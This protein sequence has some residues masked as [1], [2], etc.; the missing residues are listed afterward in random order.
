MAI[1][2][3][4]LGTE[5]LVAEALFSVLLLFS[6]GSLFGPLNIINL[7]AAGAILF[8][9]WQ[10][11][12]ARPRIANG[13]ETPSTTTPGDLH[14]AYAGALA[15]GRVTDNQLEA[16]VLEMV[17]RKVIE[18]EPDQNDREKVQIRILQ[19]SE[20]RNPVETELISLLKSRATSGVIDYRTLSRVRNQWGSVRNTLQKDLAYK[21]WLN[22]SVL[23]TRMPFILPGTLGVLLAFAMIP[24]AFIVGSGWPLLG[25]VIVGIVGCIVLIIGNIIP[26]TTAEGEKEALPWRGYRTGLARARDESSNA[27]D[28]DEAFPYIVAM[29]MAPAF[30]RY[31]RRAS[32]SG[33]I[34]IWIGPRPRVQEWPEGW[35][36]YWI[37]VHTALAPTD[38]ANTRAPSGSAWRRS[39]TG[40]R[41]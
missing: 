6:A 18:L 37:A 1:A 15:T 40:G 17:R 8:I 11:W 29:G 2:S 32:Q 20:T 5:T 16:A 21:G 13:H 24:G 22:P 26:Q 9:A 38:S 19:P 28:L 36:T 30:D 34:P 41:F 3:V 14:P 25:G 27:L 7:L 33:Y 31:L 35:H 12:S 4:T 39:L 23:Q 10:A